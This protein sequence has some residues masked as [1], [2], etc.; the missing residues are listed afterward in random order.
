MEELFESFETDES[1][2]WAVDVIDLRELSA[3]ML[4]KRKINLNE[5]S[6]DSAIGLIKKALDLRVLLS[7]VYLDTI[8][9][10][11]K[12]RGKLS[13]RF[14]NIKFV[15][16]KKDG[17]LYPVVSGA[18][19]VAKFEIYLLKYVLKAGLFDV[20]D[21]N[22]TEGQMNDFLR[23]IMELKKWQKSGILSDRNRKSNKDRGEDEDGGDAASSGV[24]RT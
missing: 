24:D 15:V 18:S 11:E 16:A 12:Y 19:I 20:D 13:E 17:I 14:A 7:E 5:I 9:D 3:K 6:H 1:I 4:R 2:G 10:A 23:D 8:G 21:S 22:M